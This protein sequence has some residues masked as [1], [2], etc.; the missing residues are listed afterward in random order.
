LNFWVP[1]RR[2]I[3]LP[4]KESRRTEQFTKRADM[5]QTF[6][7]RSILGRCVAGAVVVAF[8]LCASVNVACVSAA[9]APEVQKGLAPTGKLR[10]GLLTGDA[11]QA[12]KDSTSGELKGVGFDLG[13]QLAQSLGLPFEPVLYS[14]IGALLDGGKSGSWDVA[15][16][17]FTAARAKDWDFTAPYLEVE[18]GYLVPAGSPIMTIADVDRPGIRVAVQERSGP[19]AFA[20]RALKN[21]T[22][23]RAPDYAA[24][25]E[26]QKSGKADVIFSIKPILFGLSDRMPGSRVLDGSPGTVPQAMALPKGREAGL[27]YARGFIEDAKSKGIVKAAIERVGL[28]GVVVPGTQTPSR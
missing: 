15:F 18:F 26:M 16:I 17:G 4:R 11:T 14:S 13:K 19:E 25:V 12:I 3:Y 1:N 22:L 10:V 27:P 28:R 5:R 23:V 24:A 8:F 2:S 9:P 20:S 21:A 6:V 7:R